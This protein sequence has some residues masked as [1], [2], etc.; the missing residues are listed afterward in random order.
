MKKI[1]L[2]FVVGIALSHGF[3]AC[4]KDLSLDNEVVKR[5]LKASCS[6]DTDSRYVFTRNDCG[7]NII[8]IRKQFEK[9]QLGSRL[10]N[11]LNRKPIS[12][13]GGWQAQTELQRELKRIDEQRLLREKQRSD[14]AKIKRYKVATKRAVQ[15]HIVHYYTNDVRR[16]D[17]NKKRQLRQYR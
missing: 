9:L 7:V 10:I 14:A 4:M 16:K 3:S 13:H 1:G 5:M 15:Q 17:V 6:Q 12:Y 11:D 8:D 2:S